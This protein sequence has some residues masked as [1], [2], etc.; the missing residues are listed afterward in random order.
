MKLETVAEIAARI[1]SSPPLLVA[2]GLCVDYVTEVGNL[3]ACDD[4]NLTLHRGEIL[5]IAGESASGK[6]T[7]LAALGR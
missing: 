3:R 5:G 6:S 2:D 7:L 4:I 1:A